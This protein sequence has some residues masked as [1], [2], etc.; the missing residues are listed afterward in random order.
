MDFTDRTIRVFISSTFRDMVEDRDALMTHAWPELRR[1]CRERDVEFVEVDLRWGIAEERSNRKEWLKLALDE[2]HACR[3]FF[4]GLLGERYGSQPGAEAFTADLMEEQPWLDGLRG[5]SGTELEILHGVL[6][7]PDMAQRSFFYFRDPS[8]AA[9]HGADFLSDNQESSNRQSALKT[10]IRTTCA[11]R[12]IPLR[13]DYRDPRRLATLVVEDLQA[14]IDAQFPKASI[15]DPIARDASDH[16]AFAKSRR[17]TYIGRPDYFDVLDRH[18]AGDDLPLVVLGDAGSGKSALVANWLP[19]WRVGHPRDFVFQHY[20]GGTPDSAQYEQLMSRL[21]AEIQRWTEDREALP[22]TRDEI[23]RAFPIWLARARN[24]AERDG[25]RCVIVLDALNQLE[26]RDHARLLGWLPSHPFT[27]P[28][29]LVVSTLPGDTLEAVQT[30]GWTTFRLEPLTEEERRRIIDAYLH[31]FGKKLQA[32]RRDRIAAAPSA[33]NPL[34]LKTLLDELRVTGTHD[35]LDERLDEYL[36]EPDIP[37]LLRKILIRYTRDYERDRTGLVGDTLGLIWAA[38]RGL[39]ES[40]LLRL[41]RPT[42]LP[43]LPLALWTPFRAALEEALVDRGGVL[44]F[45]HDFLRSAVETVYVPDQERQDD[46]RIQLADYFEAEPATA[47]SC[48]ELPWLLSSAELFSRLRTCLLDI[49]R[50]LLLKERD[51]EELRGYWVDPLDEQQSMGTAYLEGFERWSKQSI[52]QPYRVSQAASEVGVFL[53]G[54]GLHAEAEPLLREA[55]D[56]QERGTGPTNP[57]LAAAVNNLAEVF[58]CTNRADEAEPLLRRALDLN[59]RTVGPND[60]FTATSLNNLAQLLIDTNRP[61]EAEPLL[62]RALSIDEHLFGE[63]HPNVASDCITLARVLQST[64]RLTHAEAS[65]RRALDIYVRHFG[66]NHPDT[67]SALRSL[68]NMLLES[69]RFDEAEPLLRQS[70]RI[71]ELSLGANHP[72]VASDLNSLG[73]VLCAMG[74]FSDALPLLFRALEINEHSGV[75]HL[76]LAIALNN[77]A[78]VLLQANRPSEA[79]PLLRRAIQVCEQNGAHDYSEC[80]A[81]LANLALL[82]HGTGRSVEAELLLREVLAIFVRFHRATGHAHPNF[83]EAVGLYALVLQDVGRSQYQIIEALRTVAP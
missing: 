59:L 82:L 4:V 76:A 66:D 11:A 60:P 28:L 9:H 42:H 53:L 39:S 40:E 72:N 34:Y 19:H 61:A 37:A 35:R 64:N 24:A 51:E 41:L 26:D 5:R 7:D 55:L 54:A 79:E 8:Y 2:I 36:E 57:N 63:A 13:E 1:F 62:R 68:G 27:G 73:A 77:L 31:R 30:R 67:A 22:R 20:I 43:K 75:D 46:C 65:I 78:N 21:I 47:R 70:L 3:P 38:R 12:K 29:R 83:R 56:I 44:N 74:Q 48:D 14:A 45:A 32:L 52:N 16:E 23:V 69:K 71:D 81:A 58:K 10:L 15:P 25:V 18:A 6:N 50:F 49:D 80:A 33:A 17:P